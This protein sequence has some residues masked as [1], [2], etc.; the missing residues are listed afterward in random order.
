MQ[1]KISDYR[2][3][4]GIL[5][6]TLPIVIL[7][8]IT[9][10]IGIW[11]QKIYIGETTAW[12]SQ[13]VG[14]DIANLFFMVPVL[15]ISSILASKNYRRAKLIWAGAM[16]T[17][18]YAFAIYCF[19]LH[20]NF[21]FL[22]YCAVLGLSV[23]SLLYFGRNHFKEDFAGWFS[24]KV[25]TKS[26]GVFLIV[27]AGLFLTLWLSIDIPAT[28]NNKASQEIVKNGLMINPVH[29][30]DYSFYLPLTII[31]G[32][33][34]IKKKSPGYFLAPVV[35]VFSICTNVNIISLTVVGYYKNVV[36]TLNLVFIFLL[37][38]LICLLFL[39]LSLRAISQEIKN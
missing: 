14:Q 22:A 13:S 12:L 16:V 18:I 23:Y 26:I 30:L 32:I 37:I 8:V 28:I 1:A 33:L 35:L 34:I 10:S 24:Q 21:L 2:S 17:N 29:V 20:F 6:F 9:S 4:I 11:Y 39:W 25:P 19:A 15:L 36:E 27:I 5:N 38:T 3:D 31:S 7:M